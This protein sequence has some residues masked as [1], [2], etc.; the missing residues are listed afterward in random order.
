MT[1][2][3]CRSTPGCRKQGGANRC[4]TRKLTGGTQQYAAVPVD[5][6]SDEGNTG[7]DFDIFDDRGSLSFDNQAPHGDDVLRDFYQSPN[8]SAQSEQDVETRNSTRD[9]S[10]AADLLLDNEA[11]LMENVLGT[12]EHD[13][14]KDVEDL[15]KTELLPYD[16]ER[17]IGRAMYSMIDNGHL[18]STQPAWALQGAIDYRSKSASLVREVDSVKHEH[19]TRLRNYILVHERRFRFLTASAQ[20]DNFNNLLELN[21]YCDARDCARLATHAAMRPNE[22]KVEYKCREHSN[23][24]MYCLFPLLQAAS[25][26]KCRGT[27]GSAQRQT[28]WEHPMVMRSTAFSSF[29]TRTATNAMGPI[30]AAEL[31]WTMFTQLLPEV[32]AQDV[33]IDISETASHTEP[34]IESIRAGRCAHIVY[35]DF[36]DMTGDGVIT[37]ALV[38]TIAKIFKR[39][40]RDGAGTKPYNAYKPEPVEVDYADPVDDSNHKVRNHDIYPQMHEPQQRF[41][42]YREY[43]YDSI[44]ISENC[45]GDA[46]SYYEMQGN[47]IHNNDIPPYDLINDLGFVPCSFQNNA[48][49]MHGYIWHRAL[50]DSDKLL[51]NRFFVKEG[52]T[53]NVVMPLTTNDGF[54]A[55]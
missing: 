46:T 40:P 54:R 3:P 55:V 48:Q 12:P 24:S 36:F 29:I 10:A 7:A 43:M 41:E 31:A 45:G 20:E 52:D 35:A 27:S 49:S 42:K 17:F 51:L 19:C 50:P 44:F 33:T 21:S 25:M 38:Y 5:Y 13:Y 9:V 6:D 4:S 8:S 47:T 23:G 2:R 18:L 30:N 22:A 53:Q 1:T 26:F 16:R 37:T 11:Q 14:S 28:R 15:G 34:V 39:T 32:V